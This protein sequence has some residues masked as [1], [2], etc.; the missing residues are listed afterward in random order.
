MATKQIPYGLT[1]FE[2]IRTANYYYVDKTRYI[3]E[4][5]RNASF[6]F[7]IRP[8]RFGKSLF[9]NVLRW[10][11]DVN[12]KD[13]FE[14]LFGDLY[15]G[16][17][18]T[19]EQGQ[20]LVLDFNFAGVNPDPD[21]LI[22]SFNDHCA[23][24]FREFAYYYERFF[25]PGFRE[26]MESLPNAD[27]K[28]TYT[29]SE[30]KR[31]NL[32]IYLFIDEYD[33]FTNAILAN[34][35]EKHYKALTHGTGFFR[36]FFNKLKEG[37]TGD[38]PIKRMFITGVSPVTMDD[39][40]SGFNIGAN[41]TTDYRFNGIIGFSEGEVWEMLAYYKS[42][43]GFEDSVDDLI[44]LMKPWYD[45]Y[46]FSEEC[47]DEPMYNSD[48]VLYF[49]SNYLSLHKPPKNMIDNNIRT[50]YNKLRH[51]IH[52]DKTFGENAS[53]VQEIV[54]KGSTTGII[55]NSFPA[56]DII[57]P[58]N[59]KSLLYYYGMLTISGMEMGEP[60]LSVPN[61][62]VR[63]QLYGYMADIYK[64]SA[65]LYLETDK[66]VDRMKR[67]AYKGEWENCFTYIADRLNAQSSVRDF[68]EGEAYVK[69]FILA[70]LGL[71]HYYIARPEYESNKGYADIFLQPRL[72]Q[73]PDMVYSYCIEVKYAKRDASDTEIEKLLCNAK[74]Q[75]KQYAASEWIHQDKGTTE[76]KSIAL[77]F[78]GWKLVRVEEV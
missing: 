15:I 6:F 51:L 46:C 59:F 28:L 44:N 2:R 70:Y 5:E 26:K 11:Y 29:I 23:A 60:I 18:P 33:N 36:Y 63:E 72:L 77:V 65:D 57:K 58:E 19:P 53:V 14:E 24:R 73:L 64:D 61:W 76:L 21:E 55:A 52:V 48:M 71:T 10:Y 37:A 75:L 7:L 35:G 3:A 49:L 38:G 32:S 54:E 27:E 74:I 62:A 50:D 16:S 13:S 43:T 68:I 56:E 20:Y 45:N 4:V 69:T 22:R 67:M 30:A 66:L 34:M 41:M 1:D 42:E 17:H 47:M 40:T 31:L 25:N 9:L 12:R 39:V 78:Q 8:R